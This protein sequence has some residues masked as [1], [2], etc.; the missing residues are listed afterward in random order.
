MIQFCIR[1]GSSSIRFGSVHCSVRGSVR[2]MIQ[3]G[4][5]SIKF[6]LGLGSV[7]SSSGF[8][9]WFDLA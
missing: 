2:Y 4:S 5:C 1:F 7:R 9:C 6:G 8:G 3:F